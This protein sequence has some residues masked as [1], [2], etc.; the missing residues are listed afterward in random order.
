M[1]DCVERVNQATER[2]EEDEPLG[3]RATKAAVLYAN[4]NHPELKQDHP[5]WNDRVKHIH[6]IWRLLDANIRQ[7]YVN[8]ARENRANRA[9]VS[10]LFPFHV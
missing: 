7:E 10:S 5:L 9:R 3:D 8:K 2:W 4:I 6:R 1:D